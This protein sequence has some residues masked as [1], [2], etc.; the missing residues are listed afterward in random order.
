[1]TSKQLF[2]RVWR[3]LDGDL[4]RRLATFAGK[5]AVAA[6]RD[7]ARLAGNRRV[8]LAVTG[9]SRS[10]KTVFIT[11]LVNQLLEATAD[12]HRLARVR[13]VQQGRYLGAREVLQPDSTV[14]TFRYAD[15]LAE[16]Y[17]EPPSWPAGT[18]DISQL[19]LHL[20]AKPDGL[21]DNVLSEYQELH[22]DVTD[23]P[24]E[25]LV[26][27]PMLEQDFDVW[28]ATCLEQS[29]GSAL[30]D[31]SAPWRE[32][33]AAEDLHRPCGRERVER[34]HVLF[35]DY[36]LAAKQAGYNFLQPGRVL[37]PGALAGSPAVTFC[38]CPPPPAEA[39]P[40]SLYTQLAERYAMYRRD[41]I[42]PFYQQHF[43]RF[44]C[45]VVL[46]DLMYALQ[47]GPAHFA[48]TQRTL[49]TLLQSFN[50]GR[51]SL[52]RRLFNPKIDRVLFAA[53]KVDQVNRGQYQNLQRL[54]A[55]MLR[56]TLKRAEFHNVRSSTLALASVRATDTVSDPDGDREFVRGRL[57]AASFEQPP[58]ELHYPPGALPETLP[59]T[60]SWR[61]QPFR[62]YA[63]HPPRLDP[64]EPILPHINMDLAVEFLLG[65]KL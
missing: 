14:A 40:G 54:L 26:D 2:G 11:S 29:A 59:D 22:L 48:D 65:D 7:L 17:A 20:R 16:L 30:A 37:L 47:Q 49:N 50:H 23:Y 43:A 4:Q 38:P 3:R 10:G 53:T 5:Q 55:A 60:A 25:W 27:L 13:A 21:L 1:M 15:H 19:R 45:Q 64:D 58:Q 41:V 34:A 28:S 18:T 33:M 8:R 63:F 12:R 56:P 6:A 52:L 24:G 51:S 35:R 9:L 46:T 61:E 36:L 39:Q 31:L 32:F 42:K 44:D 62:F 57:L